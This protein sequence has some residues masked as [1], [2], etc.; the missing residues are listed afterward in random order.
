MSNYFHVDVTW[1]FPQTRNSL[2]HPKSAKLYG[3]NFGIPCV[4]CRS[5]LGNMSAFY[6]DPSLPFLF[7]RCS[8][9]WSL[10]NNQHRDVPLV[11]LCLWVGADCSGGI[12]IILKNACNT[13]RSLSLKSK[14]R[15]IT[16]YW[17]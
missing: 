13:L 12:Y 10:Q 4:I 11:G 2:A 1:A 6:Y 8:H 3:I 7:D 14:K 17:P 15:V 5:N 9:C 16:W